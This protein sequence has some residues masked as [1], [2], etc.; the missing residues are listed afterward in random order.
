MKHL[1][2]IEKILLEN[3]GPNYKSYICP[4]HGLYQNP[5]AHPQETH[6]CHYCQKAYPEVDVNGN[7]KSN[8]L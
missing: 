1:T 3:Q 5:I 7:P 2:E 4:E 6:I 8:D